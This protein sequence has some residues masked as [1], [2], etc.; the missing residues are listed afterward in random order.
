MSFGHQGGTG[1]GPSLTPA[2]HPSGAWQARG[3][4]AHH[5][6]DAALRHASVGGRSGGG[7]DAA[8]GS[9]RVAR[10]HDRRHVHLVIKKKSV[11]H[12]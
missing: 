7:H 9:H 12:N 2:F 1:H 11:N 3:H 6:L 10:N 4:S 8:G 5:E